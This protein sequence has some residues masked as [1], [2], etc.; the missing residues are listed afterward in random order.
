MS[1]QQLCCDLRDRGLSLRL[2]RGRLIVRPRE[3]ITDA[4][5]RAIRR[6][7][8]E[9][10]AIVALEAD[11]PAVSPLPHRIHPVPTLCLGPT[12]CA[13]LGICGRP[14]CMTDEERGAFE[15]AVF[16]ARAERNP[17]RVTRFMSLG[18]SL[19]PFGEPRE[20]AA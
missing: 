16:N 12:A 11:A 13:V 20:E 8:A 14:A 10:L 5:D 4:D 6:H 19:K 9:L 18:I 17:H 15:V 1:A 2:E 3:L 7:R